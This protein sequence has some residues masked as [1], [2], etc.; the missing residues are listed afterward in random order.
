M[1]TL[2]LAWPGCPAYTLTSAGLRWFYSATIHDAGSAP[3]L[4]GCVYPAM[5]IVTE[6][7][8]N[9]AGR[10]SVYYTGTGGT[11][12][13]TL[14]GEPRQW[15]IEWVLAEAMQANRNATTATPPLFLETVEGQAALAAACAVYAAA[16]DTNPSC[17]VALAW[18]GNGWRLVTVGA[19]SRSAVQPYYV[20]Q[21]GRRIPH[22]ATDAAPP[23]L[24]RPTMD[25]DCDCEW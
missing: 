3:L 24:W 6:Y 18:A 8:G 21:R 16:R 15:P 13:M 1:S 7:D 14:A 5:R 11:V 2:I 19:A 10:F 20:G 12:P 9:M 25:P 23:A 4:T 17:E 22:F